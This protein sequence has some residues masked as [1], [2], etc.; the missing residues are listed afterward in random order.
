[1]SRMRTALSF[2]FLDRYAGF[3][4]TLAASLVI[5]RILTPAEIGVWSVT[6][7]VLA[8][9]SML[10]DFGAGQYLVQSP[11][12]DADRIRAVWTVQLGIGWALAAIVAAASAPLADFYREPVMREMLLVVAAGFAL[13][14]LGSLTQA[15][16]TR[17]L[18][19]DRLS[20]IRF[21]ANATVAATSVL[22]AWQGSG[23]LSLAWASLAGTLA[24]VLLCLC[25]RPRG[26][27]WL[28]G[29]RGVR[30]AISFG[31]SLTVS[32][33][34][35]TLV[36]TAPELLLGR[37]QGMGAAGLYSRAAGLIA[38]FGRLVS[39]TVASVA[40]PWFA[41]RRR[42][43]EGLAVPFFD[44]TACVTGLGWPFS[45]VVL[46]LAHPMLVVLFGSQWGDA[47]DAARILAV[48]GGFTIVA[49]MTGSAL[50]ASGA[51]GTMLRASLASAAETLILL[52]I[53]AGHSLI[54]TC[55]A[56]TL[57]TAIGALIW[58]ESARR[59]VGFGW[60]DLLR[61]LRPSAL[62][63]AAAGVGPALATV[64]FGAQPE[65]PMLAIGVGLTGALLGFVLALRSSGH[66]LHREWLRWREGGPK[67][68]RAAPI[69]EEQK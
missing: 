60:P 12:L 33:I 4:V 57:S 45:V 68:E 36:T 9:A 28:P 1:M 3:V 14:P 40:T 5:A 43:G 27:P 18:R 55:A 67:N 46:F 50:V 8:Y 13:N 64:L 41:E 16:L 53:A 47:A 31:S 49:A 69:S 15:A 35:L 11:H 20:L 10:R 23:P 30:D 25:Y 61:S 51:A 6:A 42:N 56:V 44:A 7:G 37:L 48:G 66:P 19:F 29:L 52:G 2:A 22:L 62:L 34:M 59:V 39:E 17:E 26:W 63:T 21:V 65:R 58:I 24:T 54:L 38:M 32:S